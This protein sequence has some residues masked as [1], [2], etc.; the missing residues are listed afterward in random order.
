MR[1]ALPLL[2]LLLACSE[3]SS[4]SPPSMLVDPLALDL[5]EV[6]VDGEGSATFSITNAGGGSFVVLSVSVVDGEPTVWDI[7]RDS[8]TELGEGQSSIVTVVFLP[9]AEG[10]APGRLQVRTDVPDVDTT[11]VDLSGVGTPSIGDEDED[12]VS[13]AE[14]DCDDEDGSVF[15]GNPEA[16]DGKDNDCD[17]EIPDDEVDADYDGYRLCSG[18]CDDA[19]ANV[20]PNAEEICDGKDSDCDG[21]NADDD[22][23]DTD[24]ISICD[25]DCNDDDA[26]IAPALD[27]IC[28]GKDNDC[29]GVADDVDDDNDH[30]SPC[31]G[32][33]D[34]DD[35]DPLA[36]PVVVEEGATGVAGDDEDPVGTLEEA[37]L[38]LDEVCRSVVFLPGVYTVNET[39]SA[40]DLTIAG[41]GDHPDE[42]TFHS[43]SP[44]R[45]FTVR[46]GAHLT[47]RNIALSEGNAEGDGG[48]V[49]AVGADLTLEDVSLTANHCSG[50]GG[51]VAVTSGSLTIERATFF[52]NLA[53]DD[54]GAVAVVSGSLMDTDSAYLQNQGNRGGALLADASYVSADGVT[55]SYNKAA[56][57]GGAI[58]FTAAYGLWVERSHI[59][60]NEST[61]NGGGISISDSAP[62][63]ASYIR[64]NIIQDNTAAGLGGG[65]AITGYQSDFVLGNNTIV[66]NHG[67]GEGAGVY[68][69]AASSAGLIVWANLISASYGDSGLYALPVSGA[70]V[71][72]NSVWFTSSG[73]ELGGA[74]VEGEDENRAE[75]PDFVNF[76]NNGDPT[77][78]DLRLSSGSVARN[79]GPDVAGW[80]DSDGS[81]NDRGYTGGPGAP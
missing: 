27:E 28:D 18:E 50:D 52:D 53:D 15:P 64:N 68:A 35:T 14:G 38:L 55:W 29:T 9:N 4:E 19:D 43:S 11:Y 24:G 39:I 75:N 70:N 26:T 40:I 21:R 16:C 7:Q 54:G 49:W 62:G 6:P 3:K 32:G 30:H 79:S 22:D 47:L 42:T 17:G 57:V 5:G 46:D 41:G 74:L 76:T 80:E 61:S 60:L 12:G 81:R 65:V 48:A 10:P 8:V 77:D 72:Y 31:S 33:G 25:G 37:L 44:G 20:H 2:A 23:L 78:D 59:I 71:A 13:P 34:C 73:I 58:A 67:V 51:G 63:A 69:G 36:H 45:A 56:D 1:F 66:G